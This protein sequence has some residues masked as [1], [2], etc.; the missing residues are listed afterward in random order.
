MKLHFPPQNIPESKKNKEW[1]EQCVKWAENASLLHSDLIRKNIRDQ[2]INYDLVNGTLD[3]QDMMDLLNPYSLEDT[4]IPDNIKH[5][6]IINSK[7]NVLRGEEIRRPFDFQVIVT[8][9]TA[10]SK[11][12][13]DKV[14]AVQQSLLAILQQE[15][16]DQEEF[17]QKAQE[18][19]KKFASWQDMREIRGNFLLNHYVKELDMPLMFNQGF[20]DALIVGEEI[21]RCDII[22]GEPTVERLNPLKVRAFKGGSSPR[23]EDSDIIVI[24][25]YWNLSKVYDTFYDDLSQADIRKLENRDTESNDNEENLNNFLSSLAVESI[26]GVLEPI[27]LDGGIPMPYDKHNNIRVLQVYWKSRRR[28]KKITSIDP[29]TGEMV[30]DLMPEEYKADKENGETEKLIVVNEAWEGT[31]IGKDIFVNIRPRK[32]Q[33]NRLSNP[34]KCHFGIIGSIYS[35]NEDTPYS[36]VDMMKYYNY[37]YNLVHDKLNKLIQD[38][39][40]KVIQLDLAKVPDSW[41]IDKWMYYLKT[42]HIAVVD[43]FN[44]GNRGASLGKL[45]GALNNNMAG[46]VDMDLSGAIASHIQLLESIKAEM[47]EV[48]GISRQR[49]G[50]I[51]NRETVGGVERSNL[52][53]STITEWLF[54]TH[55][56]LKKRVLE[57][58]LET[59]KIALRGTNPKF[60]NILPDTS[61]QMMMIPGDEFA[62][63]DYGLV[64]DSSSATNNLNMKIDQL[65]QAALQTQTLSFSSIIKLYSSAS[66]AEKINMIQQNEIEMQQAAQKRH[67]QE[68]QMQQEMQQKELEHRQLEM[69]LQDAINQ[70]NNETKLKIALIQAENNHNQM[71]FRTDDD[72]FSEEERLT[73]EQK[74]RQFD[75]EL[76]FKKKQWKEKREIEL[77]KLN[78]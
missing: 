4:Y 33:Y 67:E 60:Q 46:S 48:A 37:Q 5:Y 20:M 51:Y 17:N 22:N 26:D 16:Q 11:M 69:Q 65:A 47:G 24:E 72:E 19:A 53:S 55:D 54:S 34:S 25:D 23:I 27:M 35:I 7:L 64:V 6:P 43:S 42:A 75:A 9:P 66:I 49:E 56:N 18:L 62:E 31:L 2:K 14:N 50:Q 78:N 28:L 77:K 13:E 12:E 40:G 76:D 36:M 10:I 71:V 73:L 3:M 21:Y 70:R 39:L 58:F 44:E 63:C 59:A 8:N 30:E 68:M 41:D 15:V 74:D 57:C 52:Q 1:K 45:S 32:I 61:I 29:D 38:N